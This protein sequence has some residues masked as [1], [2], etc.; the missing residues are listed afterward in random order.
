MPEAVALAEKGIVA[1]AAGDVVG[2]KFYMTS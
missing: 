1:D 2:D